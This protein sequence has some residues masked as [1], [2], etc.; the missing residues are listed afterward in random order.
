[1]KLSEVETLDDFIGCDEFYSYESDY[2]GNDRYINLSNDQNERIDDCAEYGGDGRTHGE[3]IE[4][5]RDA[6]HCLM[7]PELEDDN[8]DWTVNPVFDSIMNEIDEVEKW[9]DENGSLDQVIG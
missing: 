1:M 8:G 9:H 3:V 2:Y 5:W 7:K 4:M 6:I